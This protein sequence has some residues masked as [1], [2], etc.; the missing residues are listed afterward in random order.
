MLLSRRG[1][2]RTAAYCFCLIKIKLGKLNWRTFAAAG[3]INEC[4][5]GASA[6]SVRVEAQLPRSAGC[7]Q[8]GVPVTTERE[9]DKLLVE[10]VQGGD[11]HAFDLLVSKYR[12]RLIRMLSRL[13]H[14]SGEAED[15]AQETF[16]R[17]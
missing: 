11:Q 15:I 16:I 4:F 7:G 8:Q 5:H 3:G 17:A 9:R 2:K 13:L 12:R 14:D 1:R 6:T 10:R